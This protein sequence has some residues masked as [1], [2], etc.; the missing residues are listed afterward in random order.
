MTPTRSRDTFLRQIK[1]I[2]MCLIAHFQRAMEKTRFVEFRTFFNHEMSNFVDGESKIRDLHRNFLMNFPELD[3]NT[4]LP[5]FVED[6]D[7]E[8]QEDEVR[9]NNK[10]KDLAEIERKH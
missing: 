7:Q 6:S 8:M 3:Q 5:D 10:Q 9:P 1:H 4:E 2:F